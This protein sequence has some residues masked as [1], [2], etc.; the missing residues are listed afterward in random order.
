MANVGEALQSAAK[1]FYGTYLAASDNKR[2]E[3]RDAEDDRWRRATM[4]LQERQEARLARNDAEA[5]KVTERNLQ[6]LDGQISEMERTQGEVQSF[7][8][9]MGFSPE[10]W[11]MKTDVEK[12]EMAQE[13]HALTK[14]QIQANMAATRA[15]SAYRSAMQP[16]ELDAA[17]KAAEREN[18]RFEMDKAEYE[19]FKSTKGLR[20]AEGLVNTIQSQLD[21]TNEL[22]KGY[23]NDFGVVGPGAEPLLARRQELSALMD[24]AVTNKFTPEM[25]KSLG[26]DPEA[27]KAKSA[28]SEGETEAQRIQ[29]RYGVAGASARDAEARARVEEEKAKKQFDYFYVDDTGRLQGTKDPVVIQDL[30]KKAP[31]R[32][33]DSRFVHGYMVGQPYTPRASTKVRKGLLGGQRYSLPDVEEYGVGTPFIVGP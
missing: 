19:N 15:A 14:E 31:E 27:V 29:Q 12:F 11:A 22:L 30:E 23:T 33:L 8:E 18:F 4:A 6:L 7:I 5:L 3:E 28:S 1:T 32:I 21:N 9:E 20:E 2:R 13:M 26:M 25:Y 16:F 17:K 24:A 10:M